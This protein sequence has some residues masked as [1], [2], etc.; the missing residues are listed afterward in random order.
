MAGWQRFRSLKGTQRAQLRGD[1]AAK[2]RSAREQATIA[3]EQKREKCRGRRET[4]RSSCEVNQEHA[5]EVCSVKPG[6]PCKKARSKAGARCR[7]AKT[8]AEKGCAIDRAGA[9]RAR[10]KAR[11]IAIALMDELLAALTS[12]DRAAQQE[13]VRRWS[14]QP[15]RAAA[16]IRAREKAS[17]R[18]EE[19][20][21]Q[22]LGALEDLDV[23]ALARRR[24][25]RLAPRLFRSKFQKTDRHGTEPWNQALEWV[26]AHAEELAAEEST[27]VEKEIA[28]DE[29]AHYRQQMTA[30][31]W[32]EF[33]A[34]ERSARARLAAETRSANTIRRR[35]SI[36][37]AAAPF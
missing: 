35:R 20:I 17:E 6:R 26:A 36:D 1:T 23:P 30:E 9:A 7:S 32:R 25:T 37:P 10:E 2:K 5:A 33:K 21:G 8:R 24:A 13:A 29:R 4:A 15:S 14:A 11:R 19:Q 27:A 22:F 3:A 28:R 18:V 16:A 12:D 31:Q 34:A